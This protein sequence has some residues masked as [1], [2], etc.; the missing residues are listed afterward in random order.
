LSQLAAKMFNSSGYSHF[1]AGS[2]KWAHFIRVVT[3][4]LANLRSSRVVTDIFKAK[5]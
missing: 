3:F 4:F 1:G 5:N 2:P